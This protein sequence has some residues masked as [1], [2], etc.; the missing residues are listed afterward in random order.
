M[1]GNKRVKF[2]VNDELFE[3]IEQMAWRLNISPE[4]LMVEIIKKHYYDILTV[5]KA[6]IQIMEEDGLKPQSKDA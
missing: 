5:A 3:Q 2:C 4:K 1:D 6:V